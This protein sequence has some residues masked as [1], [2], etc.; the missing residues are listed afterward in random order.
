MSTF[1]KVNLHSRNYHCAKCRTF[2]DTKHMEFYENGANSFDYWCGRCVKAEKKAV[3]TSWKPKY[4][5]QSS[6]VYVPVTTPI[7]QTLDLVL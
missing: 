4:K 7:I 3:K 5:L 2:H 6:G 1:V